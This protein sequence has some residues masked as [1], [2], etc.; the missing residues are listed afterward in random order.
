MRSR[1]DH[2]RGDVLSPSIV[3][4]PQSAA[5]LSIRGQSATNAAACSLSE[6]RDRIYWWGWGLARLTKM[7]HPLEPPLQS[8]QK[9]RSW[10][11]RVELDTIL[12]FSRL[13]RQ[14]F[15][16]YGEWR[17]R[18]MNVPFFLHVSSAFSN[19]WGSEAWRGWDFG[20][21]TVLARNAWDTRPVPD[22][23]H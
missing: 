22:E 5:R 1:N 21:L 10:W 6:T 12:W 17:A 23:Y 3:T 7:A 19:S 13:G 16:S 2:A 11:K 20:S 14:N 18:L 9:Y 4:I 8:G 15:E